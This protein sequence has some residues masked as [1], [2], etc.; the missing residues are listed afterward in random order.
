MIPTLGPVTWE[1]THELPNEDVTQ[2]QNFLEMI[3]SEISDFSL[4]CLFCSHPLLF[5]GDAGDMEGQLLLAE[6][7]SSSSSD[8]LSMVKSI[9]ST[10]LFLLDCWWEDTWC[11]KEELMHPAQSQHEKLQSADHSLLKSSKSI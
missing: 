10:F 4:H 7:S 5:I 11:S 3:Y 2:A 8:E 9:T 1:Q 6:G